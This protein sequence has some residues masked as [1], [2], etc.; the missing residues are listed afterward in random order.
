MYRYGSA[1]NDIMVKE[2]EDNY[3]PAVLFKQ[4]GWY[5]RFRTF[6]HSSR[7]SGVLYRGVREDVDEFL[8]YSGNVASWTSNIE[9]AQNFTSLEEP[10]ILRCHFENVPGIHLKYGV[11]DEYIIGESVFRQ[12]LRQGKMVDVIVIQ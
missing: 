3:E 6:V 11:E 9:V 10:T 5:D 8:D 7:V 2:W 1:E 4:L 12:I